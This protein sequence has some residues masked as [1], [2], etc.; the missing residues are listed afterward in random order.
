MSE[1]LL[2]TSKCSRRHRLKWWLKKFWHTKILR[3]EWK[4]AWKWCGGYGIVN[5]SY[6]FRVEAEKKLNEAVEQMKDK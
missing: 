5:K 1:I 6:Q 3:R 4:P 2:F